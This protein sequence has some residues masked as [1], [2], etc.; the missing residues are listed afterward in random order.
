MPLPLPG[1]PHEPKRHPIRGH[2]PWIAASCRRRHSAVAFPVTCDRSYSAYQVLQAAISAAALIS[3]PPMAATSI[4]IPAHWSV[5]IRTGIGSPP[6]APAAPN[7]HRP[8]SSIRGFVQPGFC[9]IP[10]SCTARSIVPMTRD[11][12]E[13]SIIDPQSSSDL[14]AGHRHTLRHSFATHLLEAGTD[15]RIIQVLL[16][17]VRLA[18]TAL[19]TLVATNS[20]PAPSPLDASIS[21]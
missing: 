5:A 10:Q 4:P 3:Q 21:R 20:S 2:C 13:P 8:R 17:H 15:I 1:T 7:P 16:G 19:Y 9:A 18:T 11:H 6:R 12:A 14:Q